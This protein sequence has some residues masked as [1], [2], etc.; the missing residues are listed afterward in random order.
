MFIGSL[1]ALYWLCFGVEAASD[2]VLA[3]GIRVCPSLLLHSSGLETRVLIKWAST[4][5][6]ELQLQPPNWHLNT[7]PLS[8]EKVCVGARSPDRAHACVAWLFFA[9]FT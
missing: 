9:G 3:V 5:P 4:L 6:T 8:K 7:I 1:L 2:V